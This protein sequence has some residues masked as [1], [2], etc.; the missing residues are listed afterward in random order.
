M[1]MDEK[2]SVN[3]TYVAFLAV[4]ATLGGFLFGFDSS[5]MNAAINGFRP[6]L[7]L[8]S[9]QVGFVTAVALLGCA[10]GAWFAGSVSERF[11]RVRVMHGAAVLILIGS[12]G[13]ALGGQLV[14]MGCFRMLTGLGI[15]AA[16]AVVPSYVAEISP[17][18][19][20]GRLGTF[21][22]FA[23]V[24][25]QFLGLLSGYV[26]TELAG[27]EAAAVP[28]GGS[29][30]RWMFAVV[31]VLAM[32]YLLCSWSLPSSPQDN[33][34]FGHPDAARDT[35]TKIGG[36]DAESR[37]QNMRR[38]ATR[39]AG[40]RATVKDLRGSVLGLQGIV[41]CGLLLA[42]F[43][44]LVGINVV[45][46]YS[47]TI[48]QAVGVS[49][50]QSFYVSLFTMGLSIVSTVVAISIMDRIG[51]RTLLLTGA[52]VMVPA[53]VAMT[54]AFSTTGGADDP[55]LSQGAGITA[56]IGMNVFAVAFGITWGPIMWL[57]LGELFDSRLR[58]IA[59]AV[60]TAVNWVTNWAVTRTFPLL[61][62]AGLHIAYSLYTL[63]AVLALIFVWR[64]LPETRGRQLS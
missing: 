29:A 61:A 50:D 3:T 58:T 23:I 63:F 57:M 22:Q 48:W 56:L 16:S 46:T 25:G 17:S 24:L 28:W 53:L 2:A 52:A 47:N 34:R 19:I 62:E 55:T 32:V 7:G 18:D 41:W 33:I 11:G 38:A 21:W 64:A 4:G 8:N 39:D 49:T 60:C 40:D 37:Y 44:Q 26:L 5:T 1:T 14:V 10:A 51:R 9:S 43:Q 15:G 30:W 31:A 12:I 59:V 13:A 45:K 20:R 27:S 42:A 54:I 6:S 35:I 36:A